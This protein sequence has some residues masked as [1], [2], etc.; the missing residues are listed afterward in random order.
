MS[1]IDPQQFGALQAQVAA[2]VASDVETAKTLRALTEQVTAMRV[3]MAEARGGW[4]VLLALGG[5][6]AS[7]GSAATWLLTHLSGKGPT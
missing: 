6:S 4:K 2:L 7:L 3:Q 5:A 1:D